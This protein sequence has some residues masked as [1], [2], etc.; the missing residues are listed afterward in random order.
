MF[1]N[2]IQ[3]RTVV[4]FQGQRLKNLTVLHLFYRCFTCCFDQSASPPVAPQARRRRP[5][6]LRVVES[7]GLAVRSGMRHGEAVDLE[8]GRTE[9]AATFF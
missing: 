9:T 2:G 3:I 1:F 8:P 6:P 4:V 7:R 5:T